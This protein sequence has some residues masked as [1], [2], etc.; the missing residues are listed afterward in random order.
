[1]KK[2]YLLISITL[3]TFGHCHA[4]SKYLTTGVKE[5][6][7]SPTTVTSGITATASDS[8][9][10]A[11]PSTEEVSPL[12]SFLNSLS[13]PELEYVFG[14]YK[15]KHDKVCNDGKNSIQGVLHLY[16]GESHPLT[17]ANVLT[18]MDEV[19]IS[20]QLFVLAQSLLE[21]GFYKSHVCN[22]YHNIFGLYDSRH[23]D[24]YRFDSWESSVVGYKRFIQYRYKGGSYLAFLRRIG[25]AEDPRYITKV[26]SM[27]RKLRLQAN[28][29][30]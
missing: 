29:I 28:V 3:L 21:T 5:K 18:V 13:I 22:A 24:Y 10:L 11:R 16:N 7:T 9:S 30:D 14:I 6:T 12:R 20:N 26:A 8:I 17:I 19:G 25:Y 23:H 2:I 27:T 4:Q 15:S 1:M